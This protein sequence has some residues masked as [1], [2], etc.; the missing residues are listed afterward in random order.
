LVQKT[1]V[2]TENH[3]PHL[4][5]TI[6]ISTPQAINQQAA[7]KHSTNVYKHR[8]DSQ[9]LQVISRPSRVSD[10]GKFRRDFEA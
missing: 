7:K 4:G 1:S 10:Y 3:S 8:A 5:R 6:G 2:V 9:D